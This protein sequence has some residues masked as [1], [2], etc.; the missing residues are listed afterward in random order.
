ME[1]S[2]RKQSPNSMKQGEANERSAG[3]PRPQPIRTSSPRQKNMD[4]SLQSGLLRA[5]DVPRSVHW[6]ALIESCCKSEPPYVGCYDHSSVGFDRDF[7]SD[8][9]NGLG[10]RPKTLPCKYFYDA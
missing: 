2:R 9:L 8:V 5:G 3:R 7:Y 4:V 6:Q 1:S 10:G